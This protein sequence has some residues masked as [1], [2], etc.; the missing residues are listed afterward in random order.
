MN[1]LSLLLFNVGL[2][3]LVGQIP[4]AD[5][6]VCSVVVSA[7]ALNRHALDVCVTPITSVERPPF[8]LRVPPG[9]AG[10]SRDSWAKCDQ[11]TTPE[12]GLL[13]YPPL[14]RLGDE[15]LKGIEQAIER[16]LQLSLSPHNLRPTPPNAVTYLRNAASPSKLRSPIDNWF[17]SRYS[18]QT[19]EV[20][21]LRYL[22]TQQ[23]TETRR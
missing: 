8:S 22:R 15:T 18:L 11:V 23:I 2:N 6:I 19:P 5:R 1:R 7:E 9:Q 20:R 16:A 4:R 12:K 3:H 14:G 13:R 17:D 10:L 21:G